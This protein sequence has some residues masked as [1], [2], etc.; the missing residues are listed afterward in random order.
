MLVF[1]LNRKY[2][3][4]VISFDRNISDNSSQIMKFRYYIECASIQ[5]LKIKLDMTDLTA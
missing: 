5:L 3:L 1:V 2:N 4:N